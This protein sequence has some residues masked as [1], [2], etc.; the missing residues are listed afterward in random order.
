MKKCKLFNC[1]NTG[2]ITKGF[3]IKHYTRFLRHGNPDIN[4]RQKITSCK[5]K[6]CNNIGQITKG[7]CE[8]HYYRFYRHGDPNLTLKIRGRK[9]SL[10]DCDR[11]HSAYGLCKMHYLRKMYKENPTPH[12]NTIQTK[13]LK[14]A[15]HVARKRD[16]FSCKWY[17]CKLTRK[18]IRIDVHHIFPRSEYPEL[19]LIVKFMICYCVYHHFLFHALRG[20]EAGKLFRNIDKIPKFNNV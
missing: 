14:N 13:E 2:R 7:M 15:M 17:G 12:W 16:N 5:I 20:D 4:M 11:K 6:N 1:N 8:K 18:D 19:E 3:C 10:I 9:C